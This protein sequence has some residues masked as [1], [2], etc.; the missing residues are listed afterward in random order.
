MTIGLQIL[1]KRKWK[2]LFNVT[3]NDAM[4][5]FT[6]WITLK[7]RPKLNRKDQIWS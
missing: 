1:I 5:H 6:F 3:V 2:V 7:L 4:G